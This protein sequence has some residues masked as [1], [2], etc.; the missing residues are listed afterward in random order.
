[1]IEHSGRV[2]TGKPFPDLGL[3]GVAALMRLGDLQMRQIPQK[4]QGA[5]GIT[6]VA[7]RFYICPS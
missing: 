7:R 5:T 2:Q 6:T 3:K 4:K 1:M